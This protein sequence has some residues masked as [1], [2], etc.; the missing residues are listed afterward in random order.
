[1]SEPVD[2]VQ[3]ALA[4]LSVATPVPKT[5]IILSPLSYNH[6]FSRW[7]VRSS[8]LNSIVENPQRLHASSVG[9][10]S[11]V[12]MYPDQFSVQSSETRVD[13]KHPPEYVKRVHQ[14]WSK[15]LAQ[16]CEDSPAKLAEGDLEVPDDWHSGDI[17]LSEGT[18]SALEGVVGAIEKG[19]DAIFSSD[20][21]GCFV[22]IRPPGHHCHP[23]KPSGFCMINNVHLAIQYAADHHKLTHA[24]ILDFDLHHGDG[25]QDI[26]WRLSGYDSD[27][28]N[29][30][31]A[32][33]AKIGYFSLHDINSYPCEPGYTTID[34]VKNAS[35][36]IMA[37]N[38]CIWNIHLRSYSSEDEFNQHYSS[39][40]RALIDKA[41]EYLE[42]AS[43][44]TENFKAAVFISAGFD[45][46][47]W[48]TEAMQRHSVHVPTSY[49]NRFTKDAFNEVAS[50]YCDGR[51]LSLLEG[52]YSDGAISSGVLSHL[53]GFRNMDWQKE[54]GS[55]ATVI[56]LERACKVRPGPSLKKSRAYSS[57]AQ[58]NP[59]N[60]PPVVPEWL[61]NAAE[62]A[63][64]FW[65][66][67]EKK[68]VRSRAK[69]D[70]ITP[71]SSTSST[72]YHYLRS[73]SRYPSRQQAVPNVPVKATVHI[74]DSV[75]SSAGSVPG[76]EAV[77]QV[78]LSSVAL[79]VSAFA[80][81]QPEPSNEFIKRESRAFDSPLAER[82]NQNIER[83]VKQEKKPTGDIS[84][85]VDD[86]Q[87][88]DLQ[89]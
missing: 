2:Q 50:K 79:P 36:C 59:G 28:Y 74:D 67:Y 61:P 85:L 70:L 55:A 7:W 25:S 87:N 23:G 83:P 71:P 44:K 81:V 46:S 56:G 21:K 58:A 82:G 26:T 16:L 54:W 8:Y 4:G 39:T 88:L 24:V 34:Q 3:S 27:E 69:D 18:L 48:E 62:L 76:I 33:P 60:T 6:V 68:P 1:M 35:I 14:D 37:H 17:Y 57:F 65:K 47:E 45:A 41:A 42:N 80:E 30:D 86:L 12:S 63:K 40:Y 38:L 19:V 72:P 9:I 52:G 13:L 89:Y 31:L 20:I 73:E 5:L 53:T 11:A 43:K 32:S 84:E 10:A 75:P 29:S 66:P 49:Y 15:I 77:D 22:A 78:V 51:M 64:T